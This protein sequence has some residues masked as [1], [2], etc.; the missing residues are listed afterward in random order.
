MV[1]GKAAR[2]SVVLVLAVGVLIAVA[3]PLV[4]LVYG[5]DFSDAVVLGFILLPGVLLLGIANI[6][7]TLIV[8]LGRP[9]VLLRIALLVTPVTI[10]LYVVLIPAM[11][12]EGAALA[13]SISYAATFAPTLLA[14][15][16]AWPS[17]WQALVP[18]AE[19]LRDYALLVRRAVARLRTRTSS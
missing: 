3:L 15:R 18:R 19:D 8:A 2:Q 12:A 9:G 14:F 11:G 5:P 1:I 16:R 4:P 6:L 10:A 7:G 13:S 17:P